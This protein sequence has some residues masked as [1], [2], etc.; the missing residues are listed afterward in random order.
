MSNTV[1]LYFGSYNGDQRLVLLK[2][3][4]RQYTDKKVWEFDHLHPDH[5]P[6]DFGFL[7]TSIF[8]GNFDE[9]YDPNNFNQTAYK[10]LLNQGAFV[11]F[12]RTGQQ[13]HSWN[14]NLHGV[15]IGWDRFFVH[16]EQ[17]YKH[18]RAMMRYTLSDS[19]DQKQAWDW[20]FNNISIKKIEL[21][22]P[23]LASQAPSESWKEATPKKI[24][25]IKVR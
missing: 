8:V 15:I 22:L 19:D 18:V 21:D 23:M 6:Q 10:K 16:P 11:Q 12:A 13:T 17:A 9:A 20:V 4:R 1:N 14:I 24:S 2:N 25:K 5:I 7:D 3:P